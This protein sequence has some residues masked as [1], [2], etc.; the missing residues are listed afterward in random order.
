M[1]THTR[2]ALIYSI[3]LLV[4]SS[5]TPVDYTQYIQ[6]YW[7]LHG[8][9]LSSFDSLTALPS[10]STCQY[11][12]APDGR[13]THTV[14]TTRDT[15]VLEGHYSIHHDT[16]IITENNLIDTFRISKADNLGILNNNMCW[17]QFHSHYSRPLVYTFTRSK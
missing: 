16:L 11:H 15:T 17:S 1:S 4:F 8:G 7:D 10:G 2:Q 5:C 13:H 9:T 6:G 14:V 12:F 3:L